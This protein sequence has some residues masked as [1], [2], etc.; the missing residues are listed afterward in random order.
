MISGIVVVILFIM[1][2]N[3]LFQCLLGVEQS[4]LCL[5]IIG[6]F[7]WRLKC[8]CISS[9]RQNGNIIINNN[10]G[11][12]SKHIDIKN[13]YNNDNDDMDTNEREMNE[14]TDEGTLIEIFEL[15]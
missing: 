14:Q 9:H 7:R 12:L 8:C 2:N 1:G 15:E 10:G 5:S 6:T 11:K 13:N 3:V 4:M